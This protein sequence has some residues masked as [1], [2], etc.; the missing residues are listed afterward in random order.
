MR[1]YETKPEKRVCILARPPTLNFPHGD[2]SAKENYVSRCRERSDMPERVK[3]RSSAKMPNG[4]LAFS[5]TADDCV[6]HCDKCVIARR[7]P[8]L[9]LA[10][11][12]GALCKDCREM[13]V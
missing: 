2:P 11:L 13:K 8:Q 1:C 5:A 3:E 12:D 4:S 6:S 10:Q 9:A 7:G